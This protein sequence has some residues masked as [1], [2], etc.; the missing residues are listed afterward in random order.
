MATD[1]D[2]LREQAINDQIAQIMDL[3]RRTEADKAKAEEL[4]AECARLKQATADIKTDPEAIA[5]INSFVAILKELESLK[6]SE[7]LC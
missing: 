4:K 7:G 3:R 1:C 2:I 5:R 6:V